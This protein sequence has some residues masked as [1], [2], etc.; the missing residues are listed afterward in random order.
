MKK[1]LMAMVLGMAVCVG[2]VEALNAPLPIPSP[3][4]TITDITGSIFSSLLDNQ[5]WR[6]AKLD[7]E[8]FRCMLWY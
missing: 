4:Q 6:I 8:F 5:I 2:Q 3:N 1:K 7:N